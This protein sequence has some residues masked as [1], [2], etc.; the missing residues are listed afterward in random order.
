[1]KKSILTLTALLSLTFSAQTIQAQES[2][3]IQLENCEKTAEVLSQQRQLWD[4]HM[5][6]SKI[7]LASLTDGH[8][9]EKAAL[10]RLL[11]NQDEIGNWYKTYYG[12][13]FGNQLAK[14][15]REHILGAGGIVESLKKNDQKNYDL[16]MAAAYDKVAEISKLLAD[17]NPN[18]EYRQLKEYF[19]M[20]LQ[21]VTEQVTAR[22]NKD[23]EK[24]IKF[25]DDGRD[26]MKKMA[27]YLTKGLYQQFP[28]KF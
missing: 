1:M 16:G 20:H 25:C 22:I 26:H 10:T 5:M 3:T 14:L 13:D 11:H 2:Q 6:W 15:L 21:M 4:D 19:E 7:A 24:E 12:D 17:A 9:D 18:L 23:W 8:P 27:D 28:E